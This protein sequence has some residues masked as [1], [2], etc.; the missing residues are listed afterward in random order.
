MTAEK[1]A[2]QKTTAGTAT[3]RRRLHDDQTFWS[4]TPNI[5]A[6]ALATPTQKAWDVIIVGTGISGAL[7]AEALTRRKRRVLILDRRVPVRGSTLASTAMIQHEIDMPLSHLARLRGEADAARAWARSVR[8]VRDLVALAKRLGI[9]CGMQAKQALYLAGDQMGHRALM[10]EFQARQAAEIPAEYLDAGA[11]R[12]RFGIDRT[13]AILSP[14]SASANPAQLTAGLLKVALSRGAEIAA[15]VEVAD[16]ADLGAR[17]AVATRD[18]RLLTAGHVVF[19]T[20]YEY[21]PQM[22]SAAHRVI[23]TW[24]LASEPG[25]R[26]PPWLDGMLVWEASDPYLYFRSTP[27]GRIIAGGEDE[28][29]ATAFADG[30]RRRAKIVRILEKL[31]D[32]CGLRFRPAYAWSAP[33]GDT[34]DGLPII[35]RVPGMG[36]VHSVMGFG[37]NGITFSMIA[38][39]VVSAAILGRKD[40]DADLFRFR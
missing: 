19:C 38:A 16:V 26:R 31:R 7:M 36:R 14:A 23:S 40:P 20:G 8:A 15:P 35:D 39:Q 30:A 27:D 18:G 12:D 10:I 9:D 11:L 29:S 28:G 1:T 5:S 2:A 4:A 13:A 32:T 34:T 17:A 22:E 21:L 37:G 25:V 3:R 6:P 24:A 33:F